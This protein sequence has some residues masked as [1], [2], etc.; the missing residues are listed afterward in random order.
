M[1]FELTKFVRVKLHQY[2]ILIIKVFNIVYVIYVLKIKFNIFMKVLIAGG[3]GMIGTKIID[4][5]QGKEHEVAILS[6]STQ[7]SDKF[8]CYKWDLN[9]GYID[10][11]AIENTDVIINLTGAGIAD[12]RW[13]NARKNVLIESRVKAASVIKNALLKTNHQLTSYISSSAIGYYGNS[14]QIQMT[15]SDAPLDTSFMAECC[16]KWENEATTLQS[17]TK[18]LSIIR[19]GVVFAKDGGAFPKILLP[20][21]FGSAAY[22]GNGQQYYSWIHIDDIAEMFIYMMDKKLNGIYNGVNPHPISLKNLIQIIKQEHRGFSIMHPIPSF[23]LKLILGEMSAVVLNSNLVSA[24]KI[25]KS[26]FEFKYPDVRSAVK[27]LI[28]YR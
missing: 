12:K 21:K 16:E 20:F 28:D 15:E 13:T 1:N 18:N 25:S 3:S 17:H 14:G 23:L 9:S 8:K 2:N 22:F 24:N 4:L 11:K 26:G 27:S 10:P 5:L 6:R 7:I 19:V